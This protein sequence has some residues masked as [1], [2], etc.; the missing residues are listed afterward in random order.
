MVGAKLYAPPSPQG[1][2]LPMMYYDLFLA[3]HI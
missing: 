2:S 1:R 3:G